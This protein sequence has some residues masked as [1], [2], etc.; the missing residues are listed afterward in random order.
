MKKFLQTKK[1]DDDDFILPPSLL[2]FLQPFLISLGFFPIVLNNT[3]HAPLKKLS[4]ERPAGD[5]KKDAKKALHFDSSVSSRY[6][7]GKLL[8]KSLFCCCVFV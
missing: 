5:K 6:M 3:R 2:I 8:S 1:H 4:P 7:S